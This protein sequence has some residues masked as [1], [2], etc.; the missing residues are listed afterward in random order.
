MHCRRPH[1][2]HPRRHR[3]IEAATIVIVPRA[4]ALSDP[5][6]A[7]PRAAVIHAVAVLR[8]AVV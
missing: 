3:P 2:R 6:E 8:V 1:C 5:S 7:I 4:A